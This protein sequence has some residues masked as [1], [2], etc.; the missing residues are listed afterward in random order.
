[1]CFLAFELLRSVDLE[2]QGLEERLTEKGFAFPKLCNSWLALADPGSQRLRVTGV[3]RRPRRKARGKAQAAEGGYGVTTGRWWQVPVP[4]RTSQ[5]P[6]WASDYS[7]VTRGKGAAAEP[8]QVEGR[9]LVSGQQM[10]NQEAEG[11]TPSKD[12]GRWPGWVRLRG[13]MPLG[14]HTLRC[15]RNALEL[16]PSPRKSELIELPRID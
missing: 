6:L 2:A 10:N 12:G 7:Q 13:R 4:P 15:H 9:T 5:W 8:P 14:C 11:Q 16:G 3:G 1:M